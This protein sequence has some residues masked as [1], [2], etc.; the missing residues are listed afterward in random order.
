MTEKTKPDSLW[1]IFRW[2][3]PDDKEIVYPAGE[4]D[5]RVIKRNPIHQVPYG[6][7]DAYIRRLSN[8]HPMYRYECWLVEPSPE[9]RETWRPPTPATEIRKFDPADWME[10]VKVPDES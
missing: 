3:A 8:G 5:A 4:K 7:L 1:L 10:P 6:E 2:N 9:Y